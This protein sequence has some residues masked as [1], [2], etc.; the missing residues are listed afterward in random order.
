M[1]TSI[2]LILVI[3]VISAMI[4]KMRKSQAEEDLARR[5]ALERKRRKQ[6]EAIAQ[7][8]EVIWPVIIRPVGGKPG[9]EEDPATEGSQMTAIEFE[10]SEKKAG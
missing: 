6:K 7:D 9:S 5:K 4:W 2:F 10:P 3:L 8:D 1:K